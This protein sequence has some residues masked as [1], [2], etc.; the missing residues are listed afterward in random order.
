MRKARVTLTVEVELQIA[1][2]AI[3]RCVENEDGWR[4]TYYD[5]QTP[6]DVAEH[7]AANI[8]LAGARPCHLDGWSDLPDEAVQASDW[9]LL[10]SEVEWLDPA[11]PEG[12]SEAAR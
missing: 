9:E 6:E 10:H 8:G 12:E 1:D 2:E 11:A 3:R 4:E 5:L 7:L